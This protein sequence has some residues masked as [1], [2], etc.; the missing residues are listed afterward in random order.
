MAFLRSQA[1]PAK[2][3]QTDRC[4]W[5]ASALRRELNSTLGS[6]YANLGET[7]P[8]AFFC[9][10]GLNTCFATIWRTK[11]EF[12]AT[13]EEGENWILADGHRASTPFHES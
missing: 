8:I 11:T 9:E 12:D 3:S 6:I 1:E 7:E 10:C 4:A 13:A 2:A 5:R